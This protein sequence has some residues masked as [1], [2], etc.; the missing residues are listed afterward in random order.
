MCALYAFW[1]YF[2]NWNYGDYV[3]AWVDGKFRKMRQCF[4]MNYHDY[5]CY[6]DGDNTIWAYE[7]GIWCRLFTFEGHNRL[8][9]MKLWYRYGD[10]FAGIVYN[11][12]L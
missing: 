3:Y 7:R 5:N 2:L 10:D 8:I 11:C 4:G 1:Y 6:Y 12:G 9:Y